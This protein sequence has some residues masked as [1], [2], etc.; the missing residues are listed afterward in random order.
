[1]KN[2][3]LT[4]IKMTLDTVISIFLLLLFSP[5]VIILA[6]CLVLSLKSFNV[7]F[8]QLRPGKN[9]NIFMLIKFKTMNDS[10]DEEGKLL[11]DANRLTTFGKFL[12]ST[13][14]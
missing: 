13:S 6:P 5:I 1:M 12:R 8:T 4:F 3:Y 7:F 10:V 11:P 14:L 2:T 9:G